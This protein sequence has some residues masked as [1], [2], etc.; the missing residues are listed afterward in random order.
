MRYLALIAALLSV[1]AIGAPPP[2]PPSYIGDL[3]RRIVPTQTDATFDDYTN[4]LA[5]DLTVSIDGVS[6]ASGKPAWIAI[7]RHRLGKV[8][9]RVLG[10]VEGY[11]AILVID[12]FDDRSDLPASS[13]ML[14]DPRY[15]TRAIQYRI[16]DDHLVHA[17]RIVQADGVIQTTP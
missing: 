3:A 2:P 10:Y 11:N 5:D 12:R 13:T 14:F 1:P 17:I 7:E 16:G 8:D 9:R 6:V 15:K 4:A